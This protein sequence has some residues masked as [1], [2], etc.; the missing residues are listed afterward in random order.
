[1]IQEALEYIHW[2]IKTTNSLP[3][4]KVKYIIKNFYQHFM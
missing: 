4:T 3:Y 1:M 2:Y